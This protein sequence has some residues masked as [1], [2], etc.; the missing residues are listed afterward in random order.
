MSITKD[1]I[2]SSAV[3]ILTE[4]NENKIRQQQINKAIN[5]K[6]KQSKQKDKHN[7]K[8]K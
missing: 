4:I 3:Q 5:Q 7:I 2:L 6:L 1:H 8:R